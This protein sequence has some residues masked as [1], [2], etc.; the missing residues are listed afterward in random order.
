MA[1]EGAASTGVDVLDEAL[2]GLYW[3]DNV[4]WEIDEEGS[5]K[6]FYRAIARRRADYDAAVYLS[7]DRPPEEITAAYPGFDV[8]DARP[9]SGLDAAED[10]LRTVLERCERSP[11]SLLL[12]DPLEILAERWD[13]EA[14]RAFFARC[15]PHLLG[16]GAIAYWTLGRTGAAGAL[17]RGVAE[18]TQCVLTLGDGR[19]R[20]AK[21]DARGPGVEGS[22]FRCRIEDG[23][24][25]LEAAPA[26]ARLG[27]A[28]RA[29]R[30][31]RHLSQSDL[32]RLL[33][34]SP[35]AVS[36]AERGRRGLSLETLLDACTKL[37]LT[38][39]D[40]LRGDVSPGYRLARRHDPRRRSDARPLPLLDDMRAG[41]RAYLV[42]LPP[43]GQSA[44]HLTHKGVELVAVVSG[45]VQVLLD[46][47]RPVLRPG[48]T[49]LAQ[50]SAIV[51]WRN[52]GEDEATL[53]WVLRD[54]A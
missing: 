10:L 40:L 44:P 15:C 34:I 21:A 20:I 14:A 25:R 27:T 23:H 51:G 11:R 46:A 26:A 4:V 19:L 32:A 54:D 29:V 6:P 38:L 47:G 3:G 36:Q 7:L 2:D 37:D 41:M 39:D 1:D 31:Q 52:L 18:V 48:E 22:V 50:R 13:A 28:L 35:S 53:F 12:V 5:A 17:R 9:G 45:L 30:M 33:G 43:R 16:A 24:P 49:L 8:I 42:T